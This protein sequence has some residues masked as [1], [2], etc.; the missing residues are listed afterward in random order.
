M[1]QIKIYLTFQIKLQRLLLLAVFVK[2]RYRKR[3]R[4]FSVFYF[5]VQFAGKEK[6]NAPFKFAKHIFA[7][8]IKSRVKIQKVLGKFTHL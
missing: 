6:Y 7:T 5:P 8:S 4:K 1:G 2:E 3:I